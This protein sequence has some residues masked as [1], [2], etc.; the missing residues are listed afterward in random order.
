MS[1]LRDQRGETDFRE[2]GYRTML[3]CGEEQERG[4]QICA[5]R[6]KEHELGITLDI[7]TSRSQIVQHRHNGAALHSFLYDRPEPVDDARM[8]A[9]RKKFRIFFAMACLAA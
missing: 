4:K 1:L 7:A 8:F 2:Y 3:E 6:L 5:N 9:H